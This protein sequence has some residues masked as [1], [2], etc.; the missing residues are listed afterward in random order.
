MTP[1]PP[2]DPDNDNEP[3]ILDLVPWIAEVE[4]KL[5]AATRYLQYDALYPI[6]RRLWY[7]RGSPD[8]SEPAS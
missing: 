5:H 7:E 6:L 2:L 4:P 1:I 8:I 3:D